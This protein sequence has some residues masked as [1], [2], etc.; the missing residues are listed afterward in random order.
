M[1]HTGRK[2]NTSYSLL[3]TTLLLLLSLSFELNQ[4]RATM[5]LPIPPFC[6]SL[7]FFC[8]AVFL[9]QASAPLVW[10]SDGAA[11][12]LSRFLTH[13][14]YRSLP[15]S[16]SVL[17]NV[18][19]GTSNQK[20]L[21]TIFRVPWFNHYQAN[22]RRKWHPCVLVCVA[23]FPAGS[24]PTSTVSRG[25]EY[26]YTYPFRCATKRFEIRV[27]ATRRIEVC[28][29]FFPVLST[30]RSTFLIPFSIVATTG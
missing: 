29:L 18:C 28:V 13:L 25:E 4:P 10:S 21:G 1:T 15:R 24:C 12:A 17:G 30:L 27:R 6:S 19:F 5:S 7:F 2:G 8:R 23:T 14:S 20:A 3:A 26:E 22:S 11:L 16:A 9:A